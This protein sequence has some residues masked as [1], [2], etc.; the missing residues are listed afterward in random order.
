MT[1][2]RTLRVRLAT[3]SA[4]GGLALAAL[5]GLSA[6]TAH[7]ARPP[8]PPPWPRPPR[9]SPAPAAAAVGTTTVR[10]DR[11]LRRAVL[12]ANKRS[13][14]ERIKLA[15]N[16]RLTNGAGKG[17]GPLKGDLDVTDDLVIVGKGRTI[18]ARGVDR[19]FDVRG[20]SRLVLQRVKLKNGGPAAGESG[21]AVRSTGTLV[22]RGSAFLDNKVRGEGA[23]GGAIY[24]EG[25]QVTVVKSR[26]S[27]N[28]A[29]RAGG[30]I[31]ALGGTTSVRQSQS[32]TT[33]PGSLR[34]TAAPST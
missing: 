6:G 15:K 13:G 12:K 26:F 7:A 22:A 29:E 34:A 21:G 30:A 25:G 2:P 4:A 3:G 1:T 20:S 18:N 19:I 24:N 11:Q 33:R 10:N 16:I 31:E 28:R 14:K 32:S 8:R 9:P 27:G 23:S 17:N 5:T